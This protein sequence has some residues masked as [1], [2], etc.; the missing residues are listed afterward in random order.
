MIAESTITTAR[1]LRNLHERT[2]LVLPNAWDPASAALMARAGAAAV[3]TTSGGVAWSQGR[4]DG[5][6]LGRDEMLAAVARITA[7]VDVPVTADLEAGYG[8]TPDDVATTIQAALAAGVAGVNLEDARSSDGTLRPADEQAA[9]IRAARDAAFPEF[10][11]NI[12]TDVFLRQIGAPATRLDEVLSRAAAYAKAG[13]DCLFV[14]GLHDLDTLSRLTEAS[15]LPVNAMTGPGGPT[16]AELTACG[17][18]RI[19]VGTAL[20][21]AAYATVDR[22]TRELLTTGTHTALTPNVPYQDLN[23]LLA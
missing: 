20:A 22:A 14:P 13:A 19:S 3:A 8:E 17:V 10:V 2:V 12:R 5:E 15:P 21:E 6:A 16:I 1:T 9:R 11:L 7:A 23:A 18:R 4:P